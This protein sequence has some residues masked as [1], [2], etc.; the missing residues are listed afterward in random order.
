MEL[1]EKLMIAKTQYKL[2]LLSTV[3]GLQDMVLLLN[4]LLEIYSTGVVTMVKFSSI[5]QNSHM[6]LL[7]NNMETKVTLHSKLAIMSPISNHMELGLILS[8]ET[9]QY[10]LMMVLKIQISQE[11]K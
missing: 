11:L 2:D 1:K 4:I 9:I 7:N 3:I 10:M 8:S 5:S 6:M